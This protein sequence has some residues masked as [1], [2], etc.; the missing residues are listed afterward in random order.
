MKRQMKRQM[1][2]RNSML[3]NNTMNKRITAIC[4]T[5]MLNVLAAAPA[6]AKRDEASVQASYDQAV[7]RR[8]QS[9]EV[10]YWM[11]RQ[12]WRDTPS[13]VALHKN[14]LRTID[15]FAVDA[16]TGSYQRVFNYTPRAGGGE[17]T[18][19]LKY[20]KQGL[21]CKEIIPYHQK[22]KSENLDKAKATP[23]LVM[24]MQN[25]K[26]AMDPV[27]TITQG[28]KTLCQPGG[29]LFQNLGQMSGIVCNGVTLATNA[30][31]QKK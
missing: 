16:V 8:A 17:M 9:G 27:G 22:W 2:R 21:T 14:S 30:I 20:A 10:T 23:Q 15:A 1:K 26:M 5:V 19:W 12:D 7:C 31:N 11:G 3:G 25:V 24:N 18:H 6:W 13:L 28:G 4:V 29:W